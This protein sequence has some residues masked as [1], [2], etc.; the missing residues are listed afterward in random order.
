MKEVSI[1]L[2]GFGTVG[3]GVVQILEENRDVLEARVGVPVRLKR[4]A[5]LN[6]ES[7]RGV[8]VD[9]SLLTTNAMEVVRDPEISV[10]VELIG[11]YEPAKSLILEAFK[12]GK[13]VVTANKA[14]LAEHGPEVFQAAH[15]AGVDIGFEAAVAG[16][17][18]ILR[19][20]REGLVANRFDKIL[21]ILNGTC[22][23][24]L[25]AMDSTPGV[26]FDEVLKKAQELGYAE[27][28]PALDID[29]IDS[30]HKLVLVLSLTH[31]IRVPP[32]SIH[33]EGIRN[34]DPFDVAMAHEFSYKIKLL[35]IIR[36]DGDN[37]DARLH[38]TLL[39][40]DHPLARV[41]G[42]FNG[43][44]LH[45]DMVGD[46]LFYG[47]GAGRE[48]TASAV[49]GDV[50]EMARSA[51]RGE[52]GRVPP[53]GYPESWKASGKLKNISEIVTNYYLRIKAMDRPGV[54]SKVAGILGE[55]QISLH[56]VVQKSRQSS[57]AVPVV[58]LTHLAKEADLQIACEK[59]SR[60][61][62]VEGAPVILRIEDETLN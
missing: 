55:H 27:A 34:I 13:Q 2:I 50:I 32:R 15:K 18:P 22:N 59:I 4:I 17:I 10:V 25:T 35:A 6:I 45:G 47:R 54:L 20:L 57:A 40:E 43:I 41:D 49:I 46:Q 56:S 48:S 19:S 5:D 51:A 3:A 29:G 23:F 44:F 7:D 33:V 9:R 28:D 24:I 52:A 26:S 37:V 30:A 58:F 36:R 61:D 16:G 12:N 60:L 38:P 31:G 1:G 62:D 53:L 39:P 21:A 8:K 14:L 42:V 11:G